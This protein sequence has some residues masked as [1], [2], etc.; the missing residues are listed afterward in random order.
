MEG[1]QLKP[2]LA[3]SQPPCPSICSLEHHTEYPVQSSLGR[4]NRWFR[5]PL[6]NVNILLLPTNK[7]SIALS[8]ISS[9]HG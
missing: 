7:H 9:L 2:G 4:H 8:S 3:R 5:F 6:T 1:V